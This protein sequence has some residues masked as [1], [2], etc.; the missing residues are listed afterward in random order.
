MCV[1]ECWEAGG[2][3]M[4]AGLKQSGPT[5]PST[6]QPLR[7]QAETL[8]FVR[9]GIGRTKTWRTLRPVLVHGSPAL[10]LLLFF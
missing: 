5:S 7:G 9:R 3:G 2:G 6:L 1:R 4:F 10:L 8:E